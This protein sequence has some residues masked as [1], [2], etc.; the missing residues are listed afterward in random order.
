MSMLEDLLYFSSP[1]INSPPNANAPQEE[2]SLCEVD[3]NAE[4]GL[5]RATDQEEIDEI[6]EKFRS[7]LAASMDS[8]LQNLK[9]LLL[10]KNSGPEWSQSTSKVSFSTLLSHPSF[11]KASTSTPLSQNVRSLLYK[12][13]GLRPMDPAYYI[14]SDCGSDDE[15]TTTQNNSNAHQNPGKSGTKKKTANRKKAKGEN[16]SRHGHRY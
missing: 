6:I 11:S 3:V 1:L 8:E 14:A 4:K 12:E 15:P 10:S 16:S 9:K 7:N 5:I 2:G 13:V